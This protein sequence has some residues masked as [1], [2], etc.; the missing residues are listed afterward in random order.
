LSRLAERRSEIEENEERYAEYM[1]DEWK[2]RYDEE[3]YELENG[4]F[5]DVD[6]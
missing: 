4:R 5:S 2:E 6:E 3:R 1:Q